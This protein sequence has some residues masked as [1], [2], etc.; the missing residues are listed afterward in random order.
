[1]LS[2]WTA[3]APPCH[4]RASRA[5]PVIATPVQRFPLCTSGWWLPRWRPARDRDALGRRRCF[6][7]A[8]GR[9]GGGRRSS[10]I[11][12]APAVGRTAPVCLGAGESVV[13]A[14]RGRGTAATRLHMVMHIFLCVV[15]RGARWHNTRLWWT[16]SPHAAS[17]ACFH[18]TAADV[19]KTSSS[20][21][22]CRVPGRCM[23]R[24]APF[25]R[26]K[27][28]SVPL[29]QQSFDGLLGLLQ[30]PSFNALTAFQATHHRNT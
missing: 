11:S 23:G 3:G 8:A 28:A 21:R 19:S 9:R 30:T 22:Q 6:F 13:M 1:M 29:K 4:R 16:E 12:V 26:A 17:K 7:S 20:I 15:C 25:Q 2:P 24:K 18:K 27:S 10:E 5:V 14:M